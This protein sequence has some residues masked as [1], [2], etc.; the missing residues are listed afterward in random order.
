MIVHFLIKPKQAFHLS[1]LI[2]KGDATVIY[3]YKSTN[4]EL[5]K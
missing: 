4:K 5:Q 1:L 2:N 3:F